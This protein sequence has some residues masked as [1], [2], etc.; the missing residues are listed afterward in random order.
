MLEFS[1]KPFEI[2]TIK[3]IYNGGSIKACLEDNSF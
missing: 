3:K 1:W 2:S